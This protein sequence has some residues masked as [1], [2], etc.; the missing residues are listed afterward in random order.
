MG[1]PAVIAW[2]LVFVCVAALAVVVTVLYARVEEQRHGLNVHGAALNEQG[3]TIRGDVGRVRSDA[4]KGLASFRREQEG[5]IRTDRLILDG[6]AMLSGT[7]P[8]SDTSSAPA[9]G[10]SSSSSI[11]C[12]RCGGKKHTHPNPSCDC[13]GSSNGGRECFIS[14]IDPAAPAA[15]AAAPGVPS[16]SLPAPP[17]TYSDG[18]WLYLTD[19]KGEKYYKGGL[20]GT[21]AWLKDGLQVG[22]GGCVGE[23]ERSD[24]PGMA[25]QPGQSG[26]P[27]GRGSLC[28]DPEAVSLTGKGPA[29][30]AEALTWGAG[31]RR[32]RVRDTVQAGTVALGE[33]GRHAFSANPSDDK[34]L[35]L[36]PASAHAAVREGRNPTGSSGGGS[37]S[38]SLGVTGDLFV[39]GGSMY[40]GFSASLGDAYFLAPADA[41]SLQPSAATTPFDMPLDWMSSLGPGGNRI[42]GDLAVSRDLSVGGGAG[43]L[44]GVPDASG[45]SGGGGTGIRLMSPKSVRLALSPTQDALVIDPTAGTWIGTPTLFSGSMAASQASP[46]VLVDA[47]PAVTFQSGQNGGSAWRWGLDA[48]A[49]PFGS[50]MVLSGDPAAPPVLRATAGGLGVLLP[51]GT[52]PSAALD[53]AG[54]ARVSGRLCLGSTCLTEPQLLSVIASLASGPAT[55]PAGPPGPQGPEGP[56]GPAGPA[57]PVGPAAVV[58]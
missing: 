15:A 56:V 23:S 36:A 9:D 10:S 1:V 12:G 52:A 22:R 11:R 50:A 18:D 2:I 16:A 30:P 28:F 42:V 49:A 34:W 40:S 4:T 32:V 51:A 54:D 41:L 43:T 46:G 44:G 47:T 5:E 38:S 37:T 20:A 24:G 35:M 25:G 14:A 13:S 39:Q 7:A 53:V 31:Q 45:N 17:W 26:Q 8:S 21:K 3:K 57:G 58:P 55:G 19:P 6:K 48:S 33:D 27:V 29:T